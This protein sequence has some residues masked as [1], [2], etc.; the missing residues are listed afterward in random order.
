MDIKMEQK[1]G[2]VGEWRSGIHGR[3]AWLGYAATA[4]W[5]EVMDNV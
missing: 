2:L 1:Q 5:M 3:E 4:E